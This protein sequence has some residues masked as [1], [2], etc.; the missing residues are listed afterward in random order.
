LMSQHKVTSP[1]DIVLAY[2]TLANTGG[3]NQ[4]HHPSTHGFR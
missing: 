4:R 3:R 2:T 1:A